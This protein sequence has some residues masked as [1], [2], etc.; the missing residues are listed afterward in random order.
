LAVRVPIAVNPVAAAVDGASNT[1]HVA[2]LDGAVPVN[3][4]SAVGAARPP[5][6]VRPLV[7]RVRFRALRSQS[8]HWN[9]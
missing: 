6:R 5:T 7:P 2:V 4:G 9:H 1:V 8:G 3:V